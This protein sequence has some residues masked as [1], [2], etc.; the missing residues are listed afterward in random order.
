L[1]EERDH[2]AAPE[3]EAPRPAQSGGAAGHWTMSINAPEA[4]DA[5][6]GYGADC[7]DW[8]DE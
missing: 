6:H 5:W 4:R 3:P 1:Y 7:P 2:E 8:N